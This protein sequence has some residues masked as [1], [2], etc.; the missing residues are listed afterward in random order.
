METVEIPTDALI[1]CSA[2][3]LL[4]PQ[5]SRNPAIV[6]LVSETHTSPLEVHWSNANTTPE[7]SLRS[8]FI[9]T[10][11]EGRFEERN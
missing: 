2:L 11:L 6:S 10:L 1:P 8:R 9:L 7:A 5:V 4:Q 3:R